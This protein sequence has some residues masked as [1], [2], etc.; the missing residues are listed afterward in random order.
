M[1]HKIPDR[2]IVAGMMISAF[3]L[4]DVEAETCF[5]EY[6]RLKN[7]DPEVLARQILDQWSQFLSGYDTIVAL[8]PL[9][10]MAHYMKSHGWV[11]KQ[12]PKTPKSHLDDFFELNKKPVISELPTSWNK[13]RPTRPGWYWYKGP[14]FQEGKPG[15]VGVD[16]LFDLS[17]IT[18]DFLD[19]E[20]DE[21][22]LKTL[23]GVWSSIKT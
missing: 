13:E 22:D 11:L 7:I 8:N 17:S 3:G 10:Q 1:K 15:I 2:Y 14:E 4:T 23:T 18:V 21:V 16:Q 12:V 9:D 5:L 19:G 6:S 20:N